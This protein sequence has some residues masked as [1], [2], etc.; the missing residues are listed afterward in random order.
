MPGIASDAA[1]QGTYRFGG[2]DQPIDHLFVTKDHADAYIAKSA[3]VVR[4]SASSKGFAGSDHATLWADFI[5]GYRR[6]KDLT[7]RYPATD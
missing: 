6:E 3:T 7:P 4:D 1:S 2:D 5:R